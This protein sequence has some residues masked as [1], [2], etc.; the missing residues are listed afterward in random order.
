MARP[1]VGCPVRDSSDQ[2]SG[3]RTLLVGLEGV[4]ERVLRPVVEAGR[5]PTLGGLVADGT[6]APLPSQVVPEPASAWPSLYTGANPGRHGVFD[7]VVFDGYDWRPA[8]FADV[9]EHALWELLDRRGHASVV[10]N[11]PLTAP[12]AAFD[13]ALVPG[14]GGPDRPTCHPEG[15]LADLDDVVGGYR[16]YADRDAAGDDWAGES[17]RLVASRA[18]AF[19]ALADRVD[20]AFGFLAFH[21]TGR[22]LAERPEDEAA[23]AAVFDAVDDAVAAVLDATDPDAVVLASEHGVAPVAGPS[24]RVNDFLR[25]ADLLAADPGPGG[26]PPPGA[27]R[28]P[29]RPGLPDGPLERL[30]SAAAAA[31]ATSQRVAAALERVGLGGAL[32]G[33]LPDG[34]SRAARERADPASSVAYARTGTEYG[35]R[36]NR[37]GREP[38]GVV[39]PAEYPS[40]R[41]DVVDALRAVR[42][43]DG[44]RAFSAVGPAAQFFGGPHVSEGPDVVTV[45]HRYD[46]HVDASLRGR[47][48]GDP[49][50]GYVRVPRGVVALAG[51]A[52]DT[53]VAVEDPHLFDVA[54]TVLASLGVPPSG[55]M[56]GTALAPVS[57]PEPDEYA[58]YTGG[59]RGESAGSGRL[60]NP[61]RGDRDRR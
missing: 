29:A 23:V 47:Q 6:A 24:F 21:Q 57:G 17:R 48:F 8:S 45:P 55:R 13:G 18:T 60:S 46:V 39:S 30:A 56:D 7:R 34:V 49:P 26:V 1:G 12:P 37:A 4:C 25:D 35:V 28:R 41:S 32:G 5:A 58:P 51:D 31:G 53:G 9:R 61:R 15:L 52:V 10:V 27:D 38:D 14:W 3:L 54:P 22:V 19:T 16:V 20:P 36:V 44:A 43:P 50:G 11:A 33:L 59:R 2:Q 42:T 40:V